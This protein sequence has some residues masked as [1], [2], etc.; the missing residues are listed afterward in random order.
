MQKSECS[1]TRMFEGEGSI[2]FR[3]KPKGLL[4]AD[5]SGVQSG[6]SFGVAEKAIIDHPK[7]A[8]GRF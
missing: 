1:G 2:G 6:G 7:R 8:I 4:I 5:R 3:M